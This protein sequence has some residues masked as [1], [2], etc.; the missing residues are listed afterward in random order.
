MSSRLGLH[1]AKRVGRAPAFVLAVAPQN[2]SRMQGPGGAEI[3]MQDHRLF[4]DTNHRLL[5]A[6][7]LFIQGQNLFHAGDILLIQ[8]RHAPHCF[9]ATV[10]DRDFPAGLGSSL[11]PP[12][13]PAL[14][15][16]HI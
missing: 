8:L 7:W 1:S 3:G 2:L 9:P 5:I 4:I 10:S 14:S 13:A 16:I 12:A 11:A 6:K 15:L